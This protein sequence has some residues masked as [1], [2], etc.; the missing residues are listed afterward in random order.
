[1]TETRVVDG[2]VVSLV[3]DGVWNELELSLIQG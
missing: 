3:L 2:A 1:V